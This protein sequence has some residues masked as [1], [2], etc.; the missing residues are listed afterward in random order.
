MSLSKATEQCLIT[1]LNVHDR[2]ILWNHPLIEDGFFQFVAKIPN[3]II[4]HMVNGF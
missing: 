3:F 1:H 2:K 4:P